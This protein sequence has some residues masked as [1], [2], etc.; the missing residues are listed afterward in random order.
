[1]RSG[2][3]DIQR[4]HR[5]WTI[6]VGPFAE[7]IVKITRHP[8]PSKMVT[9]TIDDDVLVDASAE[10]LGCAS[11]AWE[12]KFCLVGEK[13]M[14]FDVYE[15]NLDG[16]LLETRGTVV[17]RE[18]YS[19]QCTVFLNDVVDISKADFVIDEVCFR[20]LPSRA[21]PYRE[22]NVS[23]ELN[24][25]I[26]AYG[27]IV[28]RKVNRAAPTGLIGGLM[29][30][31]NGSNATDSENAAVGLTVMRAAASEAAQAGVAA[32]VSVAVSGVE[33][34]NAAAGE[35]SPIIAEASEKT[36]LKAS[37]GLSDLFASCCLVNHVEDSVE[38]DGCVVPVSA[39]HVEDSVKSSIGVEL[40][41]TE[42]T[43]S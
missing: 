5:S 15:T 37:R 24:A 8:W 18:T 26:S 35:V 33:A 30:F 32:A 21:T 6:Q 25:F 17:K 10:D 36:T 22:A 11:T 3:S 12:C 28:P 13:V 38:V 40:A 1:V 27:P 9:L 34:I 16:V 19:H 31:A 29:A 41:C 42:R 39:N 20:D 43:H 4:D 23:M 7:H 2:A 14:N